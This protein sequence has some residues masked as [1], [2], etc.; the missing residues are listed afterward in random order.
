MLT[1]WD[2]VIVDGQ[3]AFVVLLVFI[4]C[5]GFALLSEARRR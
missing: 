4:I 3:G 5:F 2:D 1:G